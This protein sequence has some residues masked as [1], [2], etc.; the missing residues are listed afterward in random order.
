MLKL[1]TENYILGEIKDMK[2]AGFNSQYPVKVMI[3]GFSDKAITS[4][5]DVS[6]F[7]LKK[8]LLKI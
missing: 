3:H 5:T 4:W 7:R 1:L 6:I 8:V 2:L